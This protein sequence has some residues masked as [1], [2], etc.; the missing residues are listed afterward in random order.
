MFELVDHP[1]SV[2]FAGPKRNVQTAPPISDKTFELSW[3]VVP[4]G[5]RLSGSLWCPE[6][7]VVM[8][9]R[10]GVFSWQQHTIEVLGK[11]LGE[12]FRKM[13]G[14]TQAEGGITEVMEP[15]V[16]GKANASTEHREWFRYY[17]LA[18]A[19]ALS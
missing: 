1:D 9:T 10:R 3:T 16:Q 18:R 13:H 12:Q 7:G 4:L 17:I 19:I 5:E 2:A 15:E 11:N 14:Y 8:E 6:L